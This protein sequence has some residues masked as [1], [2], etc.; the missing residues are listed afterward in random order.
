MIGIFMLGVFVAGRKHEAFQ[1]E[2]DSLANLEFDDYLL[3][4]KSLGQKRRASVRY[5]AEV[6]AVRSGTGWRKVNVQILVSFPDS[7]TIL[8]RAGDNLVIKSR[9]PN[10]P[11]TPLNPD[12]FD[13]RKY[14]ERKGI[15]WTVYLPKDT[16]R[17]IQSD[18]VMPAS[19]WALTISQ[20]VDGIFKSQ[21]KSP[22]S[23]GLLKAMIL[24][25]R[26]ELGP[27]LLNSY[28]SA[29]AVHVL[30]VSG[31]H[32]GVF[33]LMVS[34]ILSRLKRGKRGK[35]IYLLCI[36]LLLGTYAVI[37]G[38][39]PSVIRASLMCV[40]FALSQT[41]TRQNHSV[42]TLAISAFL[43]LLLDPLSLFSVGFQLSYAAVLGIILFYPMFKNYVETEIL[44]ARWLWQITLVSLSAQVFTFPLSIYYFH[45]FPTYFLFLNPFVIGLTTLLI[46]GAVVLLLIS[47]LHFQFLTDILAY[48]TDGIAQ[49]LNAVVQV[50]QKL[51]KYLMT[52]LN[53][54]AVEVALLVI[55]MIFVYRVLVNR[56]LDWLK[57]VALCCV[58][59]FSYATARLSVTYAT[60]QMVIHSVPRHTV[61]SVKN[62]QMAYVIADPEFKFDSINFDFHIKNYL[63][64]QGIRRIEY[65]D[66]PDKSL[67]APSLISW[68]SNSLGIDSKGGLFEGSSFSIVRS[69]KYPNGARLE[70]SPQTTFILSQE[71]GYK[72]KNQWKMVLS[73]ARNR[74]IDLAEIGAVELR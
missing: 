18:S 57:A 25:R 17:I 28:I 8:P 31:L 44:P 69:R 46:Y 33:F 45:Q 52:N 49:A 58:V 71:L 4:I 68:K 38:L 73:E 51:P 55:L 53:L 7:A 40:I 5:D 64:Y 61:L 6:K 15:A 1:K 37:T 9:V 65:V 30:A 42:N 56:E 48:L 54:D 19:N 35:W 26:D 59:F 10:R 22:D 60:T 3:E 62:G 43:I 13:Y 14:L 36:V 11:P 12:E 47:L 24:G 74:T 50:P 20:K 2:V 29:G 16:Y 63:N 34:W 27:D 72:T 41:F 39:S 67:N 21:L 70:N 66:L 32:V 23:Y